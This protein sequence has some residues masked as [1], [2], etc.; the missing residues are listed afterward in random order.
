MAQRAQTLAPSAQTL[1][2]RRTPPLWAGYRM[3]VKQGVA[4][5]RRGPSRAGLL[6]AARSRRRLRPLELR[7]E[8][9]E[10]DLPGWIHAADLGMLRVVHA[11][12]PR[13]EAIRTPRLIRRADPE[14][15]GLIT[16]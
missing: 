14:R 9:K 1:Q 15:Y 4:C 2:V 11:S 7:Y 13:G 6:H 16:G 3:T 5:A 10:E 8:N 12:A